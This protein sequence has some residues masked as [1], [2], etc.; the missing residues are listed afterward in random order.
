MTEDVAREFLARLWEIQDREGLSNPRLARE[1]ECSA[2]YIWRLRK[3]ERGQ[4]LSVS[5]V[6]RAVRRFPELAVF[7]GQGS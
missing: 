6:L 3:G 5:F 1:L 2:P 7:L 4:Q